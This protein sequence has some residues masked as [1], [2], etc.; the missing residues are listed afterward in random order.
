MAN[1]FIAR[2]GLISQNDSQITGSLEISGSSPT[3]LAI[4]NP[5]HRVHTIEIASGSTN[6][7]RFASNTGNGGQHTIGFSGHTG[8]NS[9]Q[10]AIIGK[11]DGASGRVDLYF[12]LTTGDNST[13]TTSDAVLRLDH[14]DVNFYQKVHAQDD[15]F[16][17]GGSNTGDSILYLG[18]EKRTGIARDYRGAGNAADFVVMTMGSLG[19][20]SV[21]ATHTRFKVTKEGH[22]EISGSLTVDQGLEVTGSTDINGTLSLPGISD[23]SASLAT[24]TAGGG[25]ITGV[26]AGDGLTGGGSAGS[27]TLNVVGG[28]GVTA[29]ANDVAIG[30]DVATTANVQFANITSSGNISASGDIIGGGLNINGPSNSHI[31]VGTYNVGFDIGGVDTAL[32]TGSGL[33]ISGAMADQNHHNMLKIGDIELVDVNTAFSTNEF[34]I[35][36][37]KSFKI[38]SGSDGG[39][40]AHDDNRLLEHNGTDFKIYRNNSSVFSA[41]AT[42]TIT[43]NGNDISFAATG[44]T[45]LKASSGT[46]S[47]TSYL[48]FAAS[49]PQA[50]PAEVKS[51]EINQSFPYFGGAITASAISSSGT[52]EA[53][54]NFIV[55]SSGRVGINTTSPD[56]K[57]DVAGNAGVNEY[58]YHNGDTDTYLRYQTDQ[59]DLSAGGQ[60]ASLKTTGLEIPGP[61]TASGAI[62]ASG[63]LEVGSS[64]S[65]NGVGSSISLNGD[66]G[67]TNNSGTIVLGSNSNATQIRSS[68]DVNVPGIFTANITASGNISASGT[69][70]TSELNSS[71]NIIAEG[72]IT[73]SHFQI[74]PA[75]AAASEVLF[76]IVVGSTQKAFID[77]DGD[78]SFDGAISC[79]TL[80]VSSD[81]AQSSPAIKFGTDVNTG[82]WQPADNEIAIQAN[83]G[84]TELTVSTAGVEVTNGNLIAPKTKLSKTSNTD[85]DHDGD[86]VFFGGTTS[87]STGK[88]YYYNAS[89]GWTIANADALADSKGLLAVALGTASDTNGMLIKGMVTLDHD[90][91]SVADVLYLSTT[92]GEASSTAPSGNNHVV[93]ILGYCLDAS[94]GQIYFNPS[95]DFIVITA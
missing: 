73:G 49:T 91:G 25:T 62:S 15:L 87:M 51:I 31:E 14:N 12:A 46:P 20:T 76:E 47:A 64:I 57:L 11:A 93:R 26:T 28:T 54:G 37:V 33:I 70:T 6:V 84:T 43:F 53:N 35:H 19:G 36:N 85:G 32:I 77:E 89:G 71:G 72:K 79:D 45:F 5:P 82:I 17:I 69:I 60:V 92:D 21:P 10:S 18:A 66:D 58:I 44:D 95:N 90:P 68:G 42:G 30:Q 67:I 78:A 1:E 29:N 88:I 63:N 48:L 4:G 24:A 40:V 94:D 86:V 52:I 83:G 50:T 27:V 39:D 59:I 75:S 16:E 80:T 65:L 7:M 9:M 61:I 34:L 81:G 55:D 3:F 13:A 74:N 8:A 2:K 22:T 56:Y 23:V 38:T 41:D